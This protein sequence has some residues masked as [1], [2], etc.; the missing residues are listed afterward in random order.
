MIDAG[1]GLLPTSYLVTSILFDTKWKIIPLFVQAEYALPV[2][3]PLSVGM[4]FSMYQ[5]GIDFY[6]WES[7]WTDFIIS[8]RANW[9]WGFN[10][11][12]LDF[13]T[14]LS[15]GYLFGTYED[16][17]Y[18]GNYYDADSEFYWG[19]QAGAHFYFTKFF[20]AMVETGY[21]YWLKIGVSF[22]F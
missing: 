7:K 20:G 9:H 8:T 10:I 12:W 2:G 5:Y 11:K 16:N 14:G 13:Y 19:F 21:P 1:I 3:I 17:Y 4:M 6:S 22:K 15:V 18:L